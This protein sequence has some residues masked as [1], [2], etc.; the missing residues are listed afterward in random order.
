M[1][2]QGQARGPPV[3]G[4]GGGGHQFCQTRTKSAHPNE[5][6]APKLKYREQLNT[7]NVEIVYVL[8][9]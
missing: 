5:L 2:V 9:R 3:S 4:G 1:K 6:T 7:F 8:F